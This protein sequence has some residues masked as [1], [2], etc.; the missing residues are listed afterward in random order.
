MAF[1]YSTSSS[2]NSGI[3]IYSGGIYSG[4]PVSES[5]AISDI[6][7]KIPFV[8]VTFFSLDEIQKIIMTLDIPLHS[9]IEYHPDCHFPH[10]K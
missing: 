3:S 9:D 10:D 7:C 1:T 2:S 5:Y 8:S 6:L 4:A